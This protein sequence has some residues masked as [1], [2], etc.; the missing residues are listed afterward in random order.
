MTKQDD[1]E[2][3]FH[4]YRVNNL[5]YDMLC[6]PTSSDNEEKEGD[7]LSGNCLINLKKLTTDIEK[8]L[9]CRKFSQGKGIQLKL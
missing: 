6:D 5:F 4:T 1:P 3:K 8:P 9:V 2:W 7:N